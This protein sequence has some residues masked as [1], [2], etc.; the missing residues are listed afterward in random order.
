M[1]LHEAGIALVSTYL[2]DKLQASHSRLPYRK[3]NRVSASLRD[4]F[5]GEKA[6]APLNFAPTNVS[7]S[8]N[9]IKIYELYSQ[10]LLLYARV[11]LPHPKAPDVLPLPPAFPR[12]HPVGRA[13]P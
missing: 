10:P 1:P 13:H 7:H 5:A 6:V 4:C 8:N 11:F 3:P 2:G 12:N 9:H